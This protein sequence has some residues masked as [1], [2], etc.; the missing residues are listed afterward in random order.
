[1]AAGLVL[2]ALFLC[3]PGVVPG[4]PQPA[5]AATSS[6]LNKK[7]SDVKSEL[8]AL[9]ADI[10][11]AEVARKAALGD[12]S[13]LDQ[14]IDGLEAEVA[15]AE[16]ARDQ[17]EE[18]LAALGA[19]LD[20]VT[21]EL[22]QKRAQLA[23]TER[24]LQTQQEVFNDRM[25]NI[26]KSG[27]RVVYLAALLEPGSL[28]QM[29]GRFD[30]LTAIVDQDDAILSRIKDLKVEV[31]GQKSALERERERVSALEREQSEVTERLQAV[32]QERQ[33]ALDELESA[34]A[35]KR[36]AVAAV[37]KDLA[38]WNKQED[39]LLEESDSITGQLRA[40]TVGV[41]VKPG[42]GI[43]SW[44]VAGGVSSGFGYRIHPIFNVRKM[45][46]GIDISAG[47]G[48]PI[49]ASADG[50]VVSAGWRGG[51]GKCVVV[52]H[53]GN[54]A[55]LYAHQSEILVVVGE[56][57]ERGEV[58]GKVGSTG[59]STGPHLHFE[60]RVNGSPVDPLGYL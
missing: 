17:A 51:Y 53:S 52:S 31:E 1:V 30:M 2:A 22:N 38:A 21:I 46:T 12:I 25:T 3:L 20:R 37:E 57:V 7:L 56:K 54:L 47:M 50:T 15:E 4:M 5:S 24:D 32:A 27:G 45:H 28:S 55:T 49:R 16:A 10:K 26:Y 48:T 40:L 8:E 41:T 34:R 59:Y 43:L 60:V 14:R 19:E 11:K 33:A 39:Q 18:E 36:K 35:A 9:R 58:I 44:P 42:K 6:E 13:A 23:L 29:L